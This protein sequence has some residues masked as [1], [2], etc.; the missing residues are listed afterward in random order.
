MDGLF[1]ANII[2]LILL[3][4]CCEPIGLILGIIGLI[5]CQDPQAKQNALIVTIVGA[6]VMVLGVGIRILSPGSFQIGQ[7]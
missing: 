7:Q 1:R 5:T 6:I 3:A 4:V 2:L